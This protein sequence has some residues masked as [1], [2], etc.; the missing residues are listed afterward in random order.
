MILRKR[1]VGSKLG[2]RIDRWS[3]RDEMK[4]VNVKE[5]KGRDSREPYQQFIQTGTNEKLHQSFLNE[6]K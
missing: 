4:G 2:E 6:K 5:T 3:R 1:K